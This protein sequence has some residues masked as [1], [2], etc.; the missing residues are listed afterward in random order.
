MK[1]VRP[2]TTDPIAAPPQPSGLAH[3]LLRFIV[4]LGLAI[5]ILAAAWMR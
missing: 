3:I 1:D 2:N 4:L 5:A